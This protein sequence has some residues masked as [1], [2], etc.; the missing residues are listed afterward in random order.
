MTLVHL[1]QPLDIGRITMPNRLAM[2]PMTRYRM[3]AD[4][5]ANAMVARHFAD[6][7]DAGLIFCEGG[8]VHPTGRLAA[9]VGGIT[10]ARHVAAWRLVTAAVHGAGGRIFLQLMHGGRISHSSLQPDGGAPLAPSA[11]RPRDDHIR[12]GAADHAPAEC[13][14]EMT[15][16]EI[17][18]LIAAYAQATA[19]ARD[20]GFDGVEL[21]AGNGYLPHQF[22]ASGTNLR[23]D[24][25]GGSVAKR[26]R[27]VLEALEAMIA[28]AGPDFVAAK[29][30]PV[31]THHDTHDADPRATYDHLL[32]ALDG[33]GLACL[34][35]QSTMDFVQ[36]GAP[37]FDV[38]LHARPL[39]R[40]PLFAAGNLNRWSGEGL[41]ASG[42]AD[43]VVYGRRFL[44]NPDLVQ[45]FRQGAQENPV[46]W[47]SLTTPTA[48]GYNDYPRL[49]PAAG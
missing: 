23:M 7:A 9:L 47:D 18:D 19:L 24:G 36:P 5:C 49:Y 46:E 43:A 31:T 37:L 25:W 20:A 27:F 12:I 6:R 8:Y 10:A 17:L 2:A 3:E 4:G 40:G 45:R 22:L 35:V 21:H 16:A 26:C 14:R 33:L 48:K 34:T 28:V 15:A 39:Y 32:P 44:A 30:S 13:P 11:V 38:H 1:F 42:A 41:V 29:I